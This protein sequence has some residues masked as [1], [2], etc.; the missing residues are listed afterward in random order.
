MQDVNSTVKYVQISAES[1]AHL[2]E[3]EDQVKILQEKLSAAQTEMTTKDNLVKQ[4]AKVAE[5]AV[6]GTK[7]Y[8]YYVYKMVPVAAYADITGIYAV[9]AL[10]TCS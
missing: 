9:V 1:Y 3:L 2:T 6:S 7:V 4:H 10:G 8:S 5:E